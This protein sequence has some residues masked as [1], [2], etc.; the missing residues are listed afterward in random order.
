MR[1]SVKI[2]NSQF[3]SLPVM[4][5]V[6]RPVY[7]AYSWHCTTFSVF[8]FVLCNSFRNESIY[9]KGAKEKGLARISANPLV[10][11][12]VVPTGIEPVSPA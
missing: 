7:A 4:T 6:D 10:C 8:L 2:G 1:S 3:E 12:L 9:W 11:F 5:K